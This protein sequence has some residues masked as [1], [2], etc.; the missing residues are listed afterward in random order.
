[1]TALLEARGVVRR[2]GTTVALSGVDLAL[3]PG[4]LLGLVGPDGAGKSTLLRAL[5]G[6]ITVDGGECRI[7]G[8]PWRDAADDATAH[9]GYMPQHYALYPDLSVDETLRFFGDLFDLKR[10][11]FTER[12]ARL[13][14]ITR[15]ENATERPVGA[16]SG[17]MYKKLA[18]ACALLHEPAVLVLDEPTNGVDPVSR[19]EL[20]ALLYRFVKEGMGVL[21]STPY[22]DEAARCDDVIVLREGAVLLR[23]AP[24][25]LV[26]GFRD[27][28]L[29]IRAAHRERVDALLEA[30]PRVLAR[31]P[32]G[33]RIRAVVLADAAGELR[34]AVEALG[35]EVSTVRPDFEDLY[36]AS[37]AER[38]A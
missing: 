7:G 32:A 27:V 36:L 38:A 23:G 13:L 6:L 2:F 29:E 4:R 21:I 16:L 25:A 22:M 10:D 30:D 33:E 9:L 35:A 18:L 11:V 3:E 37:I 1:M 5:V 12:R 14:H 26:S 8:I 34:A 15:L 28:V 19:R 20:W 24:E 17:G 31:T